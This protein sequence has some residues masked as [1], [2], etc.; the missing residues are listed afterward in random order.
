[1]FYNHV[2]YNLAAFMDLAFLFDELPKIFVKADSPC[3]LF[4]ISFLIVFTNI[5]QE[6]ITLRCQ[7]LSHGV[8]SLPR[9]RRMNSTGIG[10]R[11]FTHTY[12]NTCMCIQTTYLYISVRVA[13]SYVLIIILEKCAFPLMQESGDAVCVLTGCDSGKNREE[14]EGMEYLFYTQL[15]L[16]PVLSTTETVIHTTESSIFHRNQITYCGF[17]FQ[18]S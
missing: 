18:T 8:Y 6:H 10:T 14:E 16:E 2:V 1:M 9:E 4:H 3:Y 17:H 15:N 13:E 5:F 7:Y 11:C 12:V